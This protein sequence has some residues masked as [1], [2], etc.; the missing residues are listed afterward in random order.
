MTNPVMLPYQNLD[1]PHQAFYYINDL[2]SDEDDELL[3]Q[4]GTRKYSNHHAKDEP[5]Q[6]SWVFLRG[7][8]GS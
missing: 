3:L 2:T 5:I 4:L 7:S 1:V 6:V 8:Y